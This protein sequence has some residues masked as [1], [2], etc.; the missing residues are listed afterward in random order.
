M[1]KTIL[2]ILMLILGIALGTGGTVIVEKVF[3][4]GSSASAAGGDQAQTQVKKDGP[5]VSIGEFT[6]NLQ[7]GSLL[8]TSI[9]VEGVDAKAESVINAKTDFM[10]DRVNLVL[11]SKSLSDVVTPA[12][13]EKLRSDLLAQLN[14]IAGN[15]IQQVLFIT[16]VY[17]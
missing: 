14:E 17:Q 9:T 5:L 8:R 3:L 1:R 4:N 15:R 12:G 6:V 2:V 16:F 11:G 13:R 10:K 7:G